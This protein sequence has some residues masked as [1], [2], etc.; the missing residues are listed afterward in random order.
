MLDTHETAADLRRKLALAEA[1]EAEAER[2]AKAAAERR[3]AA[4]C[5]EKSL[6]AHHER[7]NIYAAKQEELLKRAALF[8]RWLN[9]VSEKLFGTGHGLEASLGDHANSTAWDLANAEDA[10][11]RDARIAAE[12]GWRF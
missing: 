7:L 2:A 8:Q 11:R 9:T 3:V 4:L 1:A 6:D 10:A 5:D 12:K